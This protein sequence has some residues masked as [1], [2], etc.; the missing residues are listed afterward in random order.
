M[1][2]TELQN[3]R[4]TFKTV[5]LFGWNYCLMSSSVII[6]APTAS[7]FTSILDDEVVIHLTI[8]TAHVQP[9]DLRL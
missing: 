9:Q 4:V 1:G 5:Y 6:F 8:M 2:Q 7:S 3:I